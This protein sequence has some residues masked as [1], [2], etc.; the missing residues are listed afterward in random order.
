M[1]VV[2]VAE[3]VR[4]YECSNGQG[5]ISLNDLVFELGWEPLAAKEQMPPTN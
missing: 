5:P 1:H 3:N 2:E 4:R